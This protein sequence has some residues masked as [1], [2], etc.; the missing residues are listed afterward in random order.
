MSHK[1][2]S[3][4]YGNHYYLLDHLAP[5]CEMLNIPL[6]LTDQQV[7]EIAN[8]YYPSLIASIKNPRDLTI[9][10]IDSEY[11]A[12]LQ[13]TSFLPNQKQL[14][15]LLCNKDMKLIVCP[16][17]NSDKGYIDPFM[18]AYTYVD[19]ALLYGNQMID[20]F[21]KKNLTVQK[22]ISMGN[23][24]LSYYKKNKEFLDELTEKNIFSHLQKDIPN[25]FYAPTWNDEED[26]SSFCDL[27]DHLIDQLPSKYNLLIKP[28]PKLKDSDVSTYYRVLQ[29]K[30]NVFV[31]EDFPLIYPILSKVDLYIGD[32][33]SIGYDFLYFQKPMIFFDKKN[34]DPKND[35]SLFL[36]KCGSNLS[37][38]SNIYDL[39][40]KMLQNNPFKQIQRTTYEYAFGNNDC[41][42]NN[43]LHIKIHKELFTDVHCRL[44]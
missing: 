16:H 36:H 9:A 32:F 40:E 17:G 27:T 20:F 43:D 39:V 13:C 12:L 15:K 42:E 5:I 38:L 35:P 33:S 21:K 4:L 14:F 7:L 6:F 26:L 22:S 24:R 2:A 29:N 1:I 18:Q 8:T 37:D 25:I 30:K 28:H 23:I 11:E 44:P 10:S 41:L 3:I 34:R 31:I 19:L